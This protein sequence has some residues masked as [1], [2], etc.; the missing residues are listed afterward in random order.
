MVKTLVSLALVGLVLGTGAIVAKFMVSTRPAPP[1]RDLTVPP[2][3]VQT[4]AIRPETLTE[5]IR[6]YGSARPYRSVVLT[7][8]VGGEIV[9]LAEGLQDGSQVR[10][11]QVL[12]RIDERRYVQRLAQANALVEAD[13]AQLGQLDVKEANLGRLLTICEQEVKVNRDE[14]RRLAGLF[15]S[16]A[17]SRKEYDFARLAYQRSLRESTSYQNEIDLTGPQRRQLQASLQGR[18]AEVEVAKLDVEHCRILAPF[19]GQIDELLVEVGERVQPGS[20]IA[21]V[22]D[23]WRIEVPIELPASAYTQV[24]PGA[25]V[26]LWAENMPDLHWSGSVARKS[27]DA[28][29]QSRT[30]RAYVEVDNREQATRLVGGFFLSAAVTGQRWDGALLVPRGAIVDD[31]VF[32]AHTLFGRVVG[33]GCFSERR[34]V[35]VKR[36]LGER[37]LVADGL[38]GGERIIVTNLDRL[39]HRG[40]VRMDTAEADRATTSS[41]AEPNPAREL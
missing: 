23:P 26:E 35:E 8:E 28:D 5:T 33:W 6:G 31:S 34:E 39:R 30:F 16:E 1:E 9:E 2:P 27:P 19:D 13:Q 40:P 20:A 7:T 17:A 10:K 25:A 3:L 36:F 41:P 15:E 14:E 24:I 29:E 32:V 21:G 37:A 18:L 11:G 22:I 38:E 4:Q 12:V